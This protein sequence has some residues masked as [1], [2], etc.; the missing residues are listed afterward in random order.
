MDLL[1]QNFF[2]KPSL[3]QLKG[4]HVTPP[5]TTTGPPAKADPIQE[6]VAG[7]SQNGYGIHIYIYP[8]AP[9]GPQAARMS[10]AV[11]QSPS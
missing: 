8:P 5:T 11:F 3:E 6:E 9:L 1:K 2:W 7:L 4:A 10:V